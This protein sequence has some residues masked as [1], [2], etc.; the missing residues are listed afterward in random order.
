M[1]DWLI[2][3]SMWLISYCSR[4]WQIVL[5]NLGKICCR[6]TGQW[7][8]ADHS[9]FWWTKFLIVESWIYHSWAHHAAGSIA[10]KTHNDDT[11]HIISAKQ[12]CKNLG[13]S[14]RRRRKLRK[15]EV[16]PSLVISTVLWSFASTTAGWLPAWKTW[17]SLGIWHRSGKSRGNC[18]LPV[19]C[20]R[21]CNGHKINMTWVLLGKDEMRKMDCK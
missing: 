6:K 4:I 20:Y 2:D 5:W 21:S 9:Q 19:M 14:L 18:G 3:W 10:V 16:E 1:F 11:W 13:K 7:W 8:S 17:K 12:L 15:H